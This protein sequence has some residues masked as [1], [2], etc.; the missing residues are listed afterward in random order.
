MADDSLKPV[1]G[2]DLEKVA[3]GKSANDPLNSYEQS[4]VAIPCGKCGYVSYINTLTREK[5]YRCD[6]CHIEIKIPKKPK[7]K[8]DDD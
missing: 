8:S 6:N 7:P 1:K 4:I 3:G 2:K 5:P